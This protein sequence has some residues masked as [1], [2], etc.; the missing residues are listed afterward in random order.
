MSQMK[1][2]EEDIPDRGTCNNRFKEAG[3]YHGKYSEQLI[4]C[5]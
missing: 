1:N 2:G 4:Q 5:D 3:N